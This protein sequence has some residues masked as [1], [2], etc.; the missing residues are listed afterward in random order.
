MRKSIFSVLLIL[1]LA[2]AMAISGCADKNVDVVK[3]GKFDS[4]PNITVGEAFGKFFT[5][6]KWESFKTSDNQQ[7]VE[8]KGDA[9]WQN[10]PANITL[11]FKVYEQG[12]E[13]YTMAVNNQPQSRFVSVLVLD[14]IMQDVCGVAPVERSEPTYESR[15]RWNYLGLRESID[16]T[17]NKVVVS[18]PYTRLYDYP[19][20]NVVE[21][22]VLKYFSYGH[23]GTVDGGDWY[24]VYL[25][26]YGGAYVKASDAHLM[27]E[28]MTVG[29]VVITSSNAKMHSRADWRPKY[30]V[31]EFKQ[32]EKYKFM[33]KILSYY[34]DTGI[35]IWNMM[36]TDRGDTVFVDEKY[37]RI[38]QAH[39]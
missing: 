15:S 28:D 2:I 7:V 22:K 32:G 1:I 10:M 21:D 11:Q 34:G 31:G 9:T 18:V 39:F 24:R 17:G 20:G 16:F 5:N 35:I 26:D 37:S 23:L 19:H 6:G 25:S 29:N 27:N 3:N 36:K 30:V 12:F 4:Y 33:G 13:F 8:F 14:T 38:T